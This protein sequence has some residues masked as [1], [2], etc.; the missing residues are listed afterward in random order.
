[1]KLTV[2]KVVAHRNGI[3]GVGF[4]AVSFSYV[5]NGKYRNAIA[6]VS[7]DDLEAKFAKEPHDPQTRVLM[8]REDNTGLDIE[9]TM[10]GDHFHND[11]C[12]YLIKWRDVEWKRLTRPSPELKEAL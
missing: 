1:M 3:C 12:K 8:F 6:T 7:Y 10:R 11:L 4:Y 9:E 5:E 2:H